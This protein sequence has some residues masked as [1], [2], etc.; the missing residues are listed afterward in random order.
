MRPVAVVEMNAGQIDSEN[1]VAVGADWIFIVVSRKLFLDSHTEIDS[2]NN[3]EQ[4][5][6][7][8]IADTDKLPIA[9]FN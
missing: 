6:D 1:A 2:K 5:H 8:D 3:A 4:F 9:A 7:G